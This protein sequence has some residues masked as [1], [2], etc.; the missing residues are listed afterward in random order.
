MPAVNVLDFIKENIQLFIANEFVYMVNEG[1][2]I[3]DLCADRLK[4]KVQKY[5]LFA[6]SFDLSGIFALFG[7]NRFLSSASLA[8]LFVGIAVFSM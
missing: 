6:G 7:E 5:T 1:I 2:R 3:R 8:V 4:I